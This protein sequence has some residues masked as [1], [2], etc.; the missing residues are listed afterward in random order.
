MK[1][2]CV[3]TSD[4]YGAWY[5][6]LRDWPI[7]RTIQVDLGLKDVVNIDVGEGGFIVGIEVILTRN[8]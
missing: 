4:K 3:E 5:M 2:D 6:P 7:R 1:R 8:K